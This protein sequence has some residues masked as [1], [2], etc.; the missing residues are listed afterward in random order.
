MNARD[1][2]VMVLEGFVSSIIVTHDGTRVGEFDPAR[3]PEDPAAR[4][5]R[6]AWEARDAR[7]RRGVDMARADAAHSFIAFARTSHM[8]AGHAGSGGPPVRGG[9][10]LPQVVAPKRR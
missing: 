5:T 8:C 9:W 4:P 7:S 6:G 1:R 2:D 3:V 10:V